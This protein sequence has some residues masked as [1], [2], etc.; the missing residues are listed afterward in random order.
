MFIGL[1]VQTYGVLQDFSCEKI[2]GHIAHKGIWLLHVLSFC[3]RQGVPLHLHDNCIAYKGIWLL[4]VLPFCVLQDFPSQKIVGR[5][6]HKDIWLLHVLLFCVPQGG[7]SEKIVCRI[8]YRDIW[9][10]HR[11]TYSLCLLIDM[12]IMYRN[13]IE[14]INILLYS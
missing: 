13:V 9:F 12:L 14:T 4:H 8:V 6:A 3:V 2:V 1:Y 5:I 10:F 7:P 11:E